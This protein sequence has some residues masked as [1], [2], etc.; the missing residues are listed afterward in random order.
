MARRDRQSLA[1]SAW[2]DST[3]SRAEFR[4]D[5]PDDDACLRWLKATRWPDGIFCERCARITPHYRV[6][7]RPSFSCEFCGHHVHPS[8]GTIFH[9]SS[10]NLVLWFE[11]IYLISSTRC[12]ISAKLLE[13]EI[14]VTYKTAWRMFNKIHS[15]LADEVSADASLSGKVGRDETYF[16]PMPRLGN[17]GR[18]PS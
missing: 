18:G 15:M 17:T 8:A 11:A 12:G 16:A 6:K 3:Y 2:S 1:C 9:K 7:S 10:T 14:G 5:F 4:R 13:R